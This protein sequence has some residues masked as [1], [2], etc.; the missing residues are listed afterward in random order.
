MA[1][2]CGQITQAL[3]VTAVLILKTEVTEILPSLLPR[4]LVRMKRMRQPRALCNLGNLSPKGRGCHSHFE[5]GAAGEGALRWGSRGRRG[6]PGWEPSGSNP[7][8]FLL[9][10]SHC[11]AL[12]DQAFPRAS[13]WHTPE[14]V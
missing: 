4:V 5:V 7:G 12:L 11:L 14:C 13:S 1:E 6:Q 2:H 8:S 10:R 9:P 3:G